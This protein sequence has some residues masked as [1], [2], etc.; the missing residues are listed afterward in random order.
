MTKSQI[1]HVL[2]AKLIARWTKKSTMEAQQFAMF[3]LRRLAK[4][5][6]EKNIVNDRVEMPPPAPG[7]GRRVL[8]NKELPILFNKKKT[9]LTRLTF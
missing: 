9:V 8:R 7:V 5:A 2:L 1:R 4:D 3:D 6:C